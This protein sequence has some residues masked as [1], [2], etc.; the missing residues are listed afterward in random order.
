MLTKL[1]LKDVGP[2]AEMEFDFAP[3]LSL[4]TGDNGLGKTFALDIAWWLETGVWAG[5]PALPRL[6]VSRRPLS[7]AVGSW[8]RH[9]RSD[10][11]LSPLLRRPSCSCRRWRIWS[12]S[13]CA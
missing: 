12:R 9:R 11:Q 1:K 10:R 7:W 5:L 4:L 13:T 8:R 3:R 6:D 2:A